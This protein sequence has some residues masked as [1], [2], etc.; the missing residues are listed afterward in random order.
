METVHHDRKVFIVFLRSEQL[1]GVARVVRGE[2]D[3][4]RVVLPVVLVAEQIVLYDL[5][6]EVV[7]VAKD[8][9]FLAGLSLLEAVTL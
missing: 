9:K 7:Q 8:V 6:T 5:V 4:G 3:E 2:R 1:F